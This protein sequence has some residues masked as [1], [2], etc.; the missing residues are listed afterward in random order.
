MSK[1]FVSLITLVAMLLCL[2]A[3]A[4]AMAAASTMGT[5]VATPADTSVSLTIDFNNSTGDEAISYIGFQVSEYSDLSNGQGQAVLANAT[6]VENASGTATA[7]F[8]GLKSGTTYYARAVYETV[9]GG[10]SDR[11]YTDAITF[12]TTIPA[13]TAATITHGGPTTV[14]G[15]KVTFKAISTDGNPEK[16]TSVTFVYTL[17]NLPMTYV[18][19][20][21]SGN[22]WTGSMDITKMSPGNY[23]YEIRAK[24]SDGTNTRDITVPG[25]TFTLTQDQIDEKPE[26]IIPGV[27]VPGNGYYYNG[28]Y[29]VPGYGYYIPGYGY[30]PNYPTTYYSYVITNNPTNISSANA[31]LNGFASNGISK[32]GFQ[33]RKANGNW[34]DTLWGSDAN[35]AY[36]LKVTGLKPGTAYYVRAVGIAGNG[37]V[38]GDPVAFVTTGGYVSNPAPVVPSVPTY[39]SYPNYTV[40]GGSLPGSSSGNSIPKTGVDAHYYAAAVLMMAGLALVA[41]AKR[42]EA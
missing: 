30:V 22:T 21:K 14:S 5:M 15:G 8:S 12:T 3:P 35:G 9:A 38:Y 31:T 1:R 36:A 39:P 23:E 25:G 18:G 10:S 26:T 42:R 2:M 27:V 4:T 29:Y 20:S 11:K 7:T 6:D 41:T 40:P 16:I 19:A 13:G 24:A 37:Y 17:N 34:G 32:A 33:V 28:Y